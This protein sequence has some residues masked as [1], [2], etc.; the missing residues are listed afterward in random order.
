MIEAGTRPPVFITLEGGPGPWNA[1]LP[2]RFH[3]RIATFGPALALAR[4]D[5]VIE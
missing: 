5:E 2:A 4:A 1:N 3:K